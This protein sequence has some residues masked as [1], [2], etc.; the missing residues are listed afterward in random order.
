MASRWC[1]MG[2]LVFGMLWTWPSTAAEVAPADL[3]RAQEGLTTVLN[4]LKAD[5]GRAADRL[6]RAGLAGKEARQ[7]LGELCAAHPEAVDCA[8]VDPR[9]R[10][11]TVEPAARRVH[12][13]VDIS[14]QEHVVRLQ[15]TRK[16]VLSKLFKSA[17][18]LDAVSMEY[19]V[20]SPK[21]EFI[22]SVSVLIRPEV[23]LKKGL[24]TG[25]EATVRVIQEEDGRI[26]Y[27]P[28][29]REIGRT[30][31]TMPSA[32]LADRFFSS[33]A[34]EKNACSSKAESCGEP[35]APRVL[36]DLYGTRWQLMPFAR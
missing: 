2:V 16:P 19:P 29:A 3:L 6:G 1:C 21:R 23:L 7:T 31:P 33:A 14:S 24:G 32:R 25:G 13:G 22:G 35:E 18:G 36:V 11:V 17:E 12:E 34:P 5:C 26:L 15:K 20:F 28:D 30:A 4:R 10:L 27:S 9:G 8:A